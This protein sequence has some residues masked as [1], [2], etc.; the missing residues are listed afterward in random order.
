VVEWCEDVTAGDWIVRRLHPFAQDVG[1]FVPAGFDDYVRVLHPIQAFRDGVPGPRWEELAAARDL[2]LTATTRFE[3]LQ[4]HGTAGTPVPLTGTLAP[5]LI[6]L[7]LPLLAGATTTPERCWFGLWDGFGSFEPQTE[8]RMEVEERPL[9]LC[10]GPLEAAAQLARPPVRQSPT[11]WWPD[12]RAWCVATEIDF[13]ST[14]VG[15]AAAL[16]AALTGAATIEALPVTL[17]TR[18]SD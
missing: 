15:G 6:E 9:A 3:Q 2:G 5:E 7:L 8:A 4:E 18:V 17:D 11:L 16:T 13:H 14:Y 1:S 10:R 12:D